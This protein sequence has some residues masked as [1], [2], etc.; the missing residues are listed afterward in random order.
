MK[1]S[2]RIST[3]DA[4][5]ENSHVYYPI[6]II[7]AGPSGIAMGCQLKS[8]LR[9]DQFKIFDRQE[10][11]GGTWWTNRYPG[12]A[13]DVPTLFYSFS[14][15][16]NYTS[17]TVFPSGCDYVMYLN[18][19][20]E[21]F[22]IAD[23]INLNTEVKSLKWKEEEE[24]WEIE[25]CRVYRE[26]KLITHSRLEI[27]RAKV[28]ISG[29][30]IL[31]NPN[32]WPE[33]VSGRNMFS[34]EILHSARW[35]RNVNLEGK[36]VVLVGSGCTAAQ[37][38]PA[39]LQTK[40]KSLTHII[41]DPPWFV[42]RIKE[43]GGKEAYAKFAPMIYGS[44][45][46]LGFLVR[47]IVCCMSEL[48]WYATFKRKTLKLRKISEKSS[49]D[50]MR[51]L[52]PQK[53]HSILTPRYSLGCKRRV[54]DNDWLQSMSDPRY[55]LTTQPWIG[56]G[57][58]EVTVGSSESNFN[59]AALPSRYPA[60]ILVL[61]TGFK[62]SQFLHPLS[63]MGR[64][65]ISLQH[66][67]KE[68]GGPQAYMGTG[69]DQ[70]P[71]FFM[72]MGPNTFVGHTS[73][74]MSIENN[75]QYILKM[76]API[77]QGHVSCLEPKPEAVEKWVQDI[78]RDMQETVFDSCQSWYND[79]GAWN[80]VIYPRSQLDFYLRC[81][82]PKFNDWIRKLSAQGQHRRTRQQMINMT[83]V[84]SIVI[85]VC[86]GVWSDRS[87][88]VLVDRKLVLRKTV[89][90]TIDSTIKAMQEARQWFS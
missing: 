7:G 14:F 36:D 88:E 76:I 60:D 59:L 69:I 73:V 38:A 82:S 43:P 62:V 70:F 83:M 13:C 64:Q 27:I 78:R 81:R 61:A 3:R 39:I 40:V 16:P 86:Y 74:I 9:F 20:V 90:T 18:K 85:A 52:A 89:L 29:A 71:N 21:R 66:V 84:M 28:V 25:I 53:Y 32:D 44:V 37:I 4:Y 22:E 42:P 77:L 50:H 2:A 46:I 8:K 87:F 80:T 56:M 31:T 75:V 51:K 10:G 5:G 45:P 68:R 19:V 63:V 1:S 79:S 23:K 48:L 58:N 49:L 17:P 57:C 47:F 41:R 34:G 67:W 11:L 24:E 12:I 26:G 33:T 55:T 54:F 35:P 6:V 15:A 65:G 30:G 72:I